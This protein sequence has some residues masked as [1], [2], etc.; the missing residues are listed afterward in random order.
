[1]NSSKESKMKKVVAVLVLLSMF[2]SALALRNPVL[3]Q[4][5]DQQ[6]GCATA[7]CE[8]WDVG[9]RQGF[10]YRQSLCY[11]PVVPVCPVPHYGEV[12]YQ[13]GYNRGFLAGLNAR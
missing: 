9:Y 1:L 5:G 7:F 13:D 11:P 3:I 4:Y 8:G 12:S 2:S 6:V 10:C